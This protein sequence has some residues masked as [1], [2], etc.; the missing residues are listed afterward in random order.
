MMGGSPRAGELL[1]QAT[2]HMR[3]TLVAAL[4]CQRPNSR[5]CEVSESVAI[6]H[7]QNSRTS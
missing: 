2:A 5:Q 3:R 4:V 7:A 1:D 6:L